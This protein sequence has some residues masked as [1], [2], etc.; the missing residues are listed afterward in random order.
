MSTSGAQVQAALPDNRSTLF[1][2]SV[3]ALFTAATAFSLRIAASGA[4]K[5]A[6]FDP[7]DIANSGRMIGDAL[8]AAF[9]GFAGSLLISSPLLDVVGTKRV[10]LL[11][12]AAFVVGAVTI[13]MAPEIASGTGVVSIVWWGMLLSGIGWGCAEAAI[14][15]LTAAIYPE[16]KTHRMNVLH[17]WWPAGIIIGGL[18]S[19][20]LFQTFDF[21]WRIAIVL[22]IL[23]ALVF[24][25][26]AISQSFPVTAAPARDHDYLDMLMV[27]VRRPTFW[28]G[29]GVN[30]HGQN[31]RSG[32]IDLRCG[33]HVCHASLC[34]RARGASVRH[35]FAVGIDNP[36]GA[37]SVSA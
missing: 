24:G 26:L 25:G 15:P 22:P 28:I 3:L 8:G 6:L 11:S 27:V 30:P 5:E 18:S 12:A 36:H 17:A 21:D 23:P 9:L 37:G 10:F 34:R 1:L 33:N 7:V 13:V 2:I 29:R 20:M 19:L 14:N 35:G 16:E 4:I 32:R 31:A